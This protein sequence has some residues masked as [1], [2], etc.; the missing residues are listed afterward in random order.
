LTVCRRLRVC[1]QLVPKFSWRE[2]IHHK[3]LTID[4]TRSF[5]FKRL[6]LAN[7]L[8]WRAITFAADQPGS[9]MPAGIETTRDES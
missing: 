5:W 8:A 9:S 3:P 7:A 2:P 4:E 6:S 1:A